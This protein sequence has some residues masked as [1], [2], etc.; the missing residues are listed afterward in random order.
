MKPATASITDFNTAPPTNNVL[1]S[2]EPPPA[3]CKNPVVFVDVFGR[4]GCM[5][6]FIGGSK[7]GTFFSDDTL[8]DS[9]RLSRMCCYLL[10]DTS[11]VN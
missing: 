5:S 1:P 6:C 10:R 3:L 7:K 8:L 9:I 4:F 2:Q 11:T